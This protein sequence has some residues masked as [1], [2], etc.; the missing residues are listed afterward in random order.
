[1]TTTTSTERCYEI[2][3]PFLF[4]W[5]ESQQAH[6]LLY[7]EGIVKLNATGG[8]ILKRCDGKTSVT[9]LIEQLHE[10]YNA[11][12]RDAVRDGVLNFLEVSHGKGWIRAKA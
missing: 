1:M 3:P 11:S 4:R 8:E 12:A 9:Q 6:V 5:E 10:A 7:P 2:R